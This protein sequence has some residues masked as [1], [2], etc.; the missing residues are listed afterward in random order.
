MPDIQPDEELDC[1]GLSC[2]LPVLKAKKAIGKL[3]PGKI[4]KV[5]ATDPGSPRDMQKLSV[6]M[7]DELIETEEGF[8]EFV[9]WFRKT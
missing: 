3:A 5:L 6:Q 9:F 1:R 8:G 7:G 4:L 2:P